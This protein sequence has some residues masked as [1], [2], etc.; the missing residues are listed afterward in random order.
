MASPTL[1]SSIT[2]VIAVNA[3]ADV[4]RRERARGAPSQCISNKL[5][6]ECNNNG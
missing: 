6:T 3:E 5:Y 1:L 2:V 4:V